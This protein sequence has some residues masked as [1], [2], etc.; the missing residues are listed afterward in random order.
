MLSRVKEASRKYAQPRSDYI[1][2]LFG[3]SGEVLTQDWSVDHPHHRGIYWAWPEVDYGTNRGDLHALQTVFARPTGRYKL[4]GGSDFAQVEA[5]NNWLWEDHEPIVQEL[6][7]IRAY[8]SEAGKGRIIDLVFEFRAL[9]DGVTVA[10]RHTNAYGG[11]NIRLVTPQSQAIFSFTDPETAV[12]RRAWS[13]LSGLFGNGVP[14][15]LTLLQSARNPDYPGDWIQYP[16]LAWCQP[17]FPAVGSRFPLRRDKP[18]VLSFRLWVHAGL[19]P[20]DDFADYGGKRGLG[21]LAIGNPK[22]KVHKAC[23]AKLFERNDLVLDTDGVYSIAKQ[24]I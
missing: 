4:Q 10:R 23:I 18:L 11:L 9:K 8:R 5:E 2:P 3:L 15:G 14:A 16:H 19:K 17:A 12:P 6:T 22:M 24:L 20:A 7:L 13:D 1:H 21:A